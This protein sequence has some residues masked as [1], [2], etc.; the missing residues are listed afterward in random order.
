MAV[1]LGD[2]EVGE[3]V[4]EA[5][6]AA[7]EAGGVDRAIVGECGLRQA[8]D[9]GRGQEGADH[10]LAGDSSTSLAGE[11]VTRVVVEPVDDL[12]TGAVG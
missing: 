10:G 8:I 5:V 3:Q 6:A 2:A 9:V 12:H 1:L 7:G 4:F 11:Q